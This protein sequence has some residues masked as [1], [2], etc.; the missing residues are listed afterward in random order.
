MGI[1]GW[2]FKGWDRGEGVAGEG[3]GERRWCQRM[4]W[5]CEVHDA[6]F[7]GRIAPGCL[8]TAVYIATFIISWMGPTKKVARRRGSGIYGTLCRIMVTTTFNTDKRSGA[9]GF[10]MPV[11]LAQSALYDNVFL[12]RCFDGNLHVT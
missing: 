2:G 8:E 5:A 9:I 10:S 3:S 6:V 12:P 1:G 4:E 11:R 7:G